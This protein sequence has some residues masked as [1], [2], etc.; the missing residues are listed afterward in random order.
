M[1]YLRLK[2]AINEDQDCSRLYNGLKK[3]VG[4]LNSMPEE[5]CP[6]DLV[7]RMFERFEEKSSSQRNLESLLKNEY[8]SK[9][10]RNYVFIGKISKLAAVIAIVIGITAT[11]VPVTKKMRFMALNKVCQQNL[12]SIG[13]SISNYAA[14][15]AGML[16]SVAADNSSSW[17]KVG[18]QNESDH[19][20]TRNLW[21]LVREGYSDVNDFACPARPMIT[22]KRLKTVNVC[23]FKRDFP[24]KDFVNY[25]FRIIDGNPV[26]VN[27]MGRSVLA[28]DSN[29]LFEENCMDKYTFFKGFELNDQLRS[30]SS[31]N[32]LGRGQNVIFADNSV[33][34]NR[35]RNHEG[36][37]IYTVRGTNSYKGSERPSDEDDV[38]LAP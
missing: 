16:P 38:F 5:K 36:D 30:A 8:E 20:N 32:H 18:S 22:D 6:D 11:Y 26:R 23:D 28:A 3:T 27:S 17:W 25:S 13:A 24:S 10:R 33:S 2:K 19:S 1:M 12:A 34:F 21:L 14:D 9:S 7:A 29:P 4:M 31:I 15:N 35:G 37:D